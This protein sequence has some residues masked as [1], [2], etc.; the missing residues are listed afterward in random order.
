[1]PAIAPTEPAHTHNI[2]NMDDEGGS[3]QRRLLAGQGALAYRALRGLWTAGVAIVVGTAAG[4]L[5]ILQRPA[6]TC[7]DSAPLPG[8]QMDLRCFSH[9][10]ALEGAAVIA[11]FV[12]LGAIVY[13]AWIVITALDAGSR[14]KA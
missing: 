10:D 13:L 1:M 4:L 9:P 12:G 6:A 8:G 7:P 11:A 2:P 14:P 3:Y 5:M